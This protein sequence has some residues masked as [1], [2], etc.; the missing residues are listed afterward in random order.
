MRRL[1]LMA[2]AVVGLSFG[3]A[4]LQAQA[5]DFTIDTYGCFGLGCSPTSMSAS[6]QGLDFTGVDDFMTSSTG[7]GSNAAGFDVAFFEFDDE[8]AGTESF[9]T[10]FTLKTTFLNPNITSA[11]DSDVRSAS[12][13]GDVNYDTTTGQVTITFTGGFERFFFTQGGWSGYF[14]YIVASQ[15]IA[16]PG[17]VETLGASALVTATPEPMSVLLLGSGLLGVAAVASRRR[18]QLDT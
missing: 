15:A 13:T 8:A 16:K 9:D 6:F 7:F 5:I 14:D 11:S 2:A 18:K 1:T 3:T 10:Q 17:S 12:V 4:P